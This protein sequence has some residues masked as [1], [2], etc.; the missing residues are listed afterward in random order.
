MTKSEKMAAAMKL[1]AERNP[2]AARM[3]TLRASSGRDFST[4]VKQGRY[5]GYEGSG[6]DCRP[7]TG[8]FSDRLEAIKALEAL[9]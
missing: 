5:Q 3:Q 2:L 6:R 9:V 7:V 4:A 1:V 8:W